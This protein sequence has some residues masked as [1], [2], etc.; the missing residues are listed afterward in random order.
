MVSCRF[1]D[2]DTAP[3]LSIKTYP[4]MAC[5]AVWMVL[6]SW[7]A[8]TS[9]MVSGMVASMVRLGAHNLLSAAYVI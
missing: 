6:M 5:L 1:D 4:D 9:T 2:H 3:P 7:A 8:V